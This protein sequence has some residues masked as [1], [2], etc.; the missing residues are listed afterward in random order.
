MGK[1]GG[2]LEITRVDAPERD[3][4]ERTADYKEFVAT[5]PVEGLRDPGPVSSIRFRAVLT[6]VL[7]LLPHSGLWRSW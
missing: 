5:L 2:F 6:L 7:S 1:L 4:R 3:P